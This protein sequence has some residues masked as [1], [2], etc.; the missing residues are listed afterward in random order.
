MQIPFYKN[1]SVVVCGPSQSGKT[2]FVLNCLRNIETLMFDEKYHYTQPMGGIYYFYKVHQP[3]FNVLARAGVQ[4]IKGCP[5]LLDI[6]AIVNKKRPEQTAMIIL[7]D[8][9]LEVGSNPAVL[10]IF[11]EGVHN[12]NL[13]VFFL[14]H[15]FYYQGKYTVSITRNSHYYV[16][17]NHLANISSIETLGRKLFGTGCAKIFHQIYKRVMETPY[18]I[19]LFDMHPRTPF[20][21]LRIRSS[22]F[23]DT[24]VYMF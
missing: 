5:D 9:M 21:D 12:S 8:L 20:P 11:T 17:T 13:F 10:N 2:T 14:T 7:D 22:I 6:D 16:F 19:M 15:N 3:I 23:N 4:F 24:H 18:N 1:S